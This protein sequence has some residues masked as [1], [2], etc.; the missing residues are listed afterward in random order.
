MSELIDLA[1]AS[2]AAWNRHDLETYL[3]FY[4]EDATYIGPRRRVHGKDD[5]RTYMTMLMEAFPDEQATV[6]T[7]ATEGNT[8]FVRYTDTALHSG[9]M[10]WSPTRQLPPS[11]RSFTY[12]GVTE[13]RFVEGKIAYAQ[14]FFDLFDLLF[15]QLGQPFPA[16]RTREQAR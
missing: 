1:R 15:I 14:D 2:M 16:P 5:I 6:E 10:R 13:L 11:G 7:V 8:V 4:A 9:Y 3:S 12:E